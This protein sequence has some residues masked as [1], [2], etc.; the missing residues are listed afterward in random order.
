MALSKTRSSAYLLLILNTILWGSAT[1]II[2][3]SFQYSSPI[4]FLLYR[5]IIASL[6]F[7]PIF[8]IYRSRHHHKINHSRTLLLAFLGGPVCLLLSFYGLSKTSAIEASILGSSSP[9]FTVLMCVI[10]LRET[11]T[12]KEWKGLIITLIGTSIIV[13]EPI[14]TGHNHVKLSFEGNLL[15]IL[16]NLIWTIFLISSKKI[17]VDPIYLSFYSFLLSIIFFFI[18]ALSQGIPL[19]LNSLALPGVLYMAIGG[20]VIGF[21]AYQE[22]HKRIEASEAVIFTYLNPAFAIPLSIF[23]LH[24]Y[25]SP[26]AIMA[27]LIIF[28]GV[29]ISEKR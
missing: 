12:R 13:F 29:Y 8:L 1:P 27:T 20:S 7:L 22:G 10:F 11:I 26:V 16:S 14:I 21:W 9:L 23:W 6:I 25:F 19:Q 15:I 5:F 17:R 18:I 2:K 4:I 3:Y 24:E 28:M